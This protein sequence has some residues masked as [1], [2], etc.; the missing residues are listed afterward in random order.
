MPAAARWTRPFSFRFHFHLENSYSSTNCDFQKSAW[1]LG[2]E[3]TGFSL[4]L[5]HE[6]GPMSRGFQP[7]AKS[8]RVWE[9]LAY[10]LRVS[11]SQLIES[12]RANPY[13]VGTTTALTDRAGGWYIFNCFNSVTSQLKHSAQIFDL[14]A[15]GRAIRCLRC[16]Q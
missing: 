2:K 16:G 8:Q 10:L 1:G 5:A 4:S 15:A 11:I 12:V 7:M 3:E 9:S 6:P 14:V 13:L